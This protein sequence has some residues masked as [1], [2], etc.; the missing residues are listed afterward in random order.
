MIMIGELNLELL[1]YL[2]IRSVTTLQ[3]RRSLVAGCRYQT[4]GKFIL[5]K[6]GL[7]KLCQNRK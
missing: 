7:N 4:K 6:L 5:Y 3:C 2:T 1:N